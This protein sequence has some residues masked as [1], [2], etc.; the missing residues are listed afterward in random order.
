M[1]YPKYRILKTTSCTCYQSAYLPGGPCPCLLTPACEKSKHHIVEEMGLQATSGPGGD[2]EAEMDSLGRWSALK[3]GHL[4]Q[5]ILDILYNYIYID[6]F[7]YIYIHIYLLKLIYIYIYTYHPEDD[8]PSY[9][10]LF[11]MDFPVCSLFF[12]LNSV[13]IY[14]LLYIYISNINY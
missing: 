9:K 4:F 3:C 11:P 10:P 1:I 14:V 7:I 2:G 5:S 6:T 13:Y 8:F 12:L